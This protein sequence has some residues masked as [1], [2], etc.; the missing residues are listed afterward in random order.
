M[1][2]RYTLLFF[3]LNYSLCC[4]SV[5]KDMRL[6]DDECK[7]FKQYTIKEIIKLN[8]KVSRFKTGRILNKR[9]LISIVLPEYV[10]YNPIRNNL[11]IYYIKYCELNNLNRFK[12]ISFGPFQMQLQFIKNI[13]DNTPAEII[14]DRFLLHCKGSDYKIL[15][16]NIEYLNQLETQWKILLFFEY[17][18]LSYYKYNTEKFLEILTLIY[19]AGS[20]EKAKNS[21]IFPKITCEDKTYLEW[22]NILYEWSEEY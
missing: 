16:K 12:A 8:N 20:I 6:L 14:E 15:I 11:E 7:E 19:N 5:E 21:K 13:L 17:N 3:S 18:N 9:S 2:F 22:S 4:L 1:A 10:T